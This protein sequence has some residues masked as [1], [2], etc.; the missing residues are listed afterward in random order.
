MRALPLGSS[1]VERTRGHETFEGCAETGP[2]V[3]LPRGHETC[4][5]CAEI[6]MQRAEEEEDEEGRRRGEE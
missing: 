3:E 5:R 1:S 4:E 2:S 6:D